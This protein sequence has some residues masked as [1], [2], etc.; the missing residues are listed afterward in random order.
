MAAAK[1]R[2]E[3]SDPAAAAPL[4]SRRRRRGATGLGL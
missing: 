1:L 3:P 2:A 4:F